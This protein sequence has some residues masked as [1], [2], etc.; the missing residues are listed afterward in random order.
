MNL[1]ICRDGVEIGEWAEDQVRVLYAKGELLPTDYYWRVGMS[2]WAPLDSLVQDESPLQPVPP[3]PKK[4]VEKTQVIKFEQKAA[5]FPR[6]APV[7]PAV[8][9]VPPPTPVKEPSGMAKLVGK[10]FKGRS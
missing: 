9:P 8:T 6:I 2:E 4:I 1:S 10:L 7:A 5:T 3:A